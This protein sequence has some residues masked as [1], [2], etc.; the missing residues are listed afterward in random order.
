MEGQNNPTQQQDAKIDK[1]GVKFKKSPRFRK[2][3]ISHK[4]SHDLC[5]TDENVNFTNF[6]SEQFQIYCSLNHEK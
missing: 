1:C 2:S 4:I 5:R 3:Q 6:T